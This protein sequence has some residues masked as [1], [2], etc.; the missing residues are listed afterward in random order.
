MSRSPEL[1]KARNEAILKAYN[2][3]AKETIGE[4][5]KYRHEA[6]LAILANKFY[7]HSDTIGKI[8]VNS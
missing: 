5:Q 8:V 2:L 3:L 7:L 4:K 6:I 1:K